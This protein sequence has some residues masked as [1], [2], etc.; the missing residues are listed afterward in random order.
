MLKWIIIILLL[1]IAALCTWRGYKNGIIRGICGILAIIL[2]LYMAGIVAKMYNSE[3]D[4]MLSPFISG[5]VDS[6]VDKVMSNDDEVV[7]HIS[8]SDKKDVYKLSYAVSRQFGL[9][10]SAASL[11]AEETAA[12]CKTV[13][14]DMCSVLSANICSKFAYIAVYCVCF[15]IA[16]IIFS[17]IGNVIN[18]SLLIP[19][20]G[21]VEPI[22][23]AILGLIKGIILMYA[24]AMFL[25][26]LGIIIPDEI[27][28]GSKLVFKIVNDNP[29][30][31]KIGI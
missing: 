30:A 26:Y 6:S 24:V 12:E 15:I 4:G 5:I 3:F 19:K 7:V 31:N 27:I 18:I 21:I 23:G 22:A 29:V 16:A 14:Q 25:R 28:E 1:G 9:V 17:V 2:S 20:L 13:N 11:I 8:D 10:D